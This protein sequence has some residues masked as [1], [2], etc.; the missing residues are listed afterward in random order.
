M[1]ACSIRTAAGEAVRSGRAARG[2]NIR[3]EVLR[4]R[5]RE[6]IEWHIARPEVSLLWVRDPVS[7]ARLRMSGRP[8]AFLP[9][10][11]GSLWFF[12][13]GVEAEAQIV[14]GPSGLC[15][16]LFV[17]PAFL[18]DLLDDDLGTPLIG[19]RHDGLDR[20]FN[21][22]IP[23]LAKPDQLS[24]L[25]TPAWALQALACV[26]RTS[27][28]PSQH[29]AGTASGLAPW[30]LRRAKDMLLAE[31]GQNRRLGEVADACR[32]S[33]SHFSRS[34]R[35]STGIS[36]H[37]WL[38]RARIEKAQEI[39]VRRE[40]SLVD[41]ALMCGFAD[42]SHFSRVF[43]RLVGISPDAWRRRQSA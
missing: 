26:A 42:Q 1:Q 24:P 35:T 31:L 2:G 8:M 21:A 39:L 19:F 34:F 38:I 23:E 43:K 33:L 11:R 12:P 18:A 22:L 30:Q 15:A 14:P 5:P 6:T 25:L 36:P 29:V 13:A 41:T 28:A 27:R 10:D 17:E 37:R 9:S 4:C 40:A 20:A 32:L 7:E 16:G 3:L